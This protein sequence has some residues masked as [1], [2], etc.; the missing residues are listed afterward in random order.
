MP[1]K[2]LP[3]TTALLGLLLLISCCVSCG[4]LGGDNVTDALFSSEESEYTYQISSGTESDNGDT[5]DASITNTTDAET[6]GS[7]TEIPSDSSDGTHTNSDTDTDSDIDNGT[8]TDEDETYED[9]GTGATPI[10]LDTS[11]TAPGTDPVTSPNTI[12]TTT[13]VTTPE[14]TTVSIKGLYINGTPIERFVV[15][16]PSGTTYDNAAKNLVTAINNFCGVALKIVKSTTA[17]TAHEI[18]IGNTGRDPDESVYGYENGKIYYKN[19][20]L[21][22]GCGSKWTDDTVVDF[23]KA[24]LLVGDADQNILLPTDSTPICSISMPARDKYIAD[25]SLMPVRWE[26]KWDPEPWMLDFDNKIAALNCTDKKHLFTVAHRADFLYYSENSIES[27]ISVWKM[28]G[29]C[30]E[31][32]IQFTKDGVPVLMHDSTLTRMTNYSSMKGKNGL[33]TSNK[34]SKWTYAQLC[35]LNLKEGQGGDGAAVT[36]YKIATLEEALRVCKDRLFIVLDKQ[37]T[38]RYCDLKGVQPNSKANYILPYMIKTGNVTSILISYGTL[39]T[40]AEG[41]LD[42]DEALK[43]QQYVYEKTGQ[44]M[45]MFLRGWTTRET[46]EPYAAALEKGS[47]TN[48]AIL[49]NG[50]YEPA[51][52]SMLKDLCKKYPKT[53][54][55][56]WTIDD[57]MDNNTYWKEIYSVGIRS[58]M[59]NNIMG[60]VQFAV[61]LK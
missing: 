5:G 7:N 56:G 34:V 44:K 12:P 52:A 51:K 21:Y 29:D 2:F 15:V 22:L 6:P 8:D 37:A 61:G 59:T 43:I 33:P 54:F 35:K 28:G 48:S 40:T 24:K 23:V 25:P 42:A 32:D 20:S 39:D 16:T 3:P 49:V 36:P 53:L 57:I 9:T 10:T 46:A 27:I 31:I 50:A 30:V 14:T 11:V 19:G 26:Y 60:L 18:V 38:W 41:T 58:I 17:A 13:P 4:I 47:L 1:K 55:A 45:Y